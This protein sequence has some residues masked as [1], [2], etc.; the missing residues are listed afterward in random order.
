MAQDH[1]QTL[2]DPKVGHK[3]PNMN[4]EHPKKYFHDLTPKHEEY[5]CTISMGEGAPARLAKKARAR[6]KR[7]AEQCHLY[8]ATPTHV[9]KLLREFGFDTFGIILLSI[10]RNWIACNLPM[11][12]RENPWSCSCKFCLR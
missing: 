12:S 2:P 5:V 1:F 6:A 3:R 11:H 10:M 7:K 8:T 4:P 9:D